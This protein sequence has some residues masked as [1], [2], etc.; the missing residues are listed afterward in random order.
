MVIAY[1]FSISNR[2][3]RQKLQAMLRMVQKISIDRVL[4]HSHKSCK[5]YSLGQIDQ[6]DEIIR[7]LKKPALLLQGDHNDARAY[8]DEQVQT[9]I[10]AFI[11]MMEAA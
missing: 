10:E 5:P 8:S 3:L 4:L 1:L 11:E 9:H 6:R 7:Q 2:S